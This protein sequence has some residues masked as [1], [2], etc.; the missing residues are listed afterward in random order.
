ME[1]TEAMRT[2]FACREFTDEPVSDEVLHRILDEARFAPSGGNRQ[3]G[4][5]VVVRDPAIRRR[6][7]ELAQPTLRVYAAQTAAGETP[8]NSVHPTAIDVEAA[9]RTPTDMLPMFSHLDEVPVVLVVTVDLTQVVSVDKDLDRVGLDTGA[10]IYPLV[11]NILLAAR[12]EG[13]GGVLTTVVAPAEAD[14][15][16]RRGLPEEHAIA[17]LIPRGRPVRQLT[18]LRRRP[19][20][21]FTTI[22]R[23]DGVPLGPAGE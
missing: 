10:S 16:A 14:V 22:D 4:H 6:L 5:V 7:G 23:Y 17:A 13:L 9:L 20:E 18:K 1:L 11:W 8:F 15:Q 12:A 19:V 2:T 21:D 3:G